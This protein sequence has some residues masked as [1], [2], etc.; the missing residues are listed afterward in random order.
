VVVVEL[1]MNM[2]VVV[3]EVAAAAVARTPLEA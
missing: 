1:Q 2:I 3:E